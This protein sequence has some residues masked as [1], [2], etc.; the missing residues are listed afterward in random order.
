MPISPERRAEVNRQNARK[1]TGPRTP[2]GKAASR[3]F[4][5][6]CHLGLAAEVGE[7]AN[8]GS[9]RG[10]GAWTYFSLLLRLVF[11]YEGCRLRALSGGE[12]VW[13]AP[14]LAGVVAN[15][16]SLGGG[17]KMAP[18]ARLDDGLLEFIGFGDYPLL[19]R[20]WYLP[21]I[22]PG[23]HVHVP[24]VLQ[25]PVREIALEADRP[26]LL[27]TDG[28]TIGFLPARVTLL[29]RALQVLTPT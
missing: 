7:Q 2:E 20:L 5:L 11:R 14:C 1:S 15:G 13:D 28:E 18:G 17:M 6:A 24:G 10:G 21:R 27:N 26:T 12:V 4:A 19:R 9:K 16:W 29:P 23:T 3:Y 25:K 8:R 22:F